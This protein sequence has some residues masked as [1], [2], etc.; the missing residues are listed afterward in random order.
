MHHSPCPEHLVPLANHILTAFSSAAII[1]TPEP[2]FRKG[3]FAH[4][5]AQI[6]AAFDL[7]PE[8]PRPS[9]N[10]TIRRNTQ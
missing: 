8:D 10:T 5:L 7:N 4:D 9:A 1:S 6:L 3:Y 2:E